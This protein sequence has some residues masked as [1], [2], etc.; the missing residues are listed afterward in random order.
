MNFILRDMTMKTLQ[1]KEITGNAQ[2]FVKTVRVQ[3][4]PLQILENNGSSLFIFREE[5]LQ[6]LMLD[7]DATDSRPPLTSEQIESIER[8]IQDRKAGRVK[9]HS[10]VFANLEKKMESYVSSK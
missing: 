9:S 1:Y 7:T 2:D 3:R 6:S 8:G 10:D 4:E 5:D